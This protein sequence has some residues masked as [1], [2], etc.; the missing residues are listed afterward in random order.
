M[1]RAMDLMVGPQPGGGGRPPPGRGP[2][3]VEVDGGRWLLQCWLGAGYK[4][5]ELPMLQGWDWMPRG[6][7]WKVSCMDLRMLSV[8]RRARG[9][10]REVLLLGRNTRIKEMVTATTVSGHTDSKIKMIMEEFKW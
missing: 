3:E 9:K 1:K 6:N 8:E 7:N 5:R 10:D 2:M 4:A